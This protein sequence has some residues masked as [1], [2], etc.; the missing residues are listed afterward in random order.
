MKSEKLKTLKDLEY[1]P[2]VESG[3]PYLDVSSKHLR[4]EAIKWVK[5]QQDIQIHNPNYANEYRLNIQ[6]I[7]NFFN[8]TA[9]DLK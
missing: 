9:E 8:L 3:I 7:K 6:W 2:L 4:E 5:F 1:I